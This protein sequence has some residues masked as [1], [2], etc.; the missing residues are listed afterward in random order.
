MS[1][2]TSSLSQVLTNQN[3]NQAQVSSQNQVG[4]TNTANS[5]SQL[6]VFTQGQLGLQ[7]QAGDLMNQIL[8]GNTT[9]FGLPQATYDAAFANF[10][11]YQ[12]PQLAA[13]HGSGSPAIG[14]AMQNLQL[15]LAGMAGQNQTQNALNTF[16]S[17]AQY[18]FQPVGQNNN[19]IGSQF[20]NQVNNGTQNTNTNTL[21]TDIGG[22]LGGTLGN[23]LN[24]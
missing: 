3:Q 10:N 18:A 8:T 13:Q 6:P 21:T 17:A 11:Q 4:Q 7:G 14:A 24:P 20:Q 1:Y 2:P 19:A 23:F 15:Q 9:Q 16:N 12:A 22:L 5:Q